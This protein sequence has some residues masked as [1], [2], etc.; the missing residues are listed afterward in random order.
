MTSWAWL[1]LVS[2]R[3]R[4]RP[5][6]VNG[7]VYGGLVFP[8]CRATGCREGAGVVEHVVVTEGVKHVSAENA[9]RCPE[10]RADRDFLRAYRALDNLA[11][12]S[13][14]QNLCYYGGSDALC[15]AITLLADA[16][17]VYG[18][19][20]IAA[21][22]SFVPLLDD[23]Q[24]RLERQLAETRWL[25]EPERS[26]FERGKVRPMTQLALLGGDPKN[27]PIP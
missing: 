1:L 2:R 16:A 18:R 22:R 7:T 5:E 3:L 19:G 8:L 6:S 24:A 13:D 21:Q 26:T 14:H 15:D 20:T 17:L 27:N 4:T 25:I 10:H 23:L 9:T 11:N 12:G